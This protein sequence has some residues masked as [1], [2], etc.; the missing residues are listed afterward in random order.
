[1]QAKSLAGDDV[2]SQ[3]YQLHHFLVKFQ[4][5]ISYFSVG[6]FSS[7]Q[8][9]PDVLERTLKAP[10]LSSQITAKRIFKMHVKGDMGRK[11]QHESS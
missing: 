9:F 1:M 2:Q 3:N 7:N 6:K 10:D 4:S 11:E 5:A 8:L